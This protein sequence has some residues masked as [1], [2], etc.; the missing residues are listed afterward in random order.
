MVLRLP[1]GDGPIRARLAMQSAARVVGPD[2]RES[3]RIAIRKRPKHHGVDDAEHRGVGADAE[4]QRDDRDGREARRSAQATRG[5]AHILPDG[6]HGA[7]PATPAHLRL[8]RPD[9]SDLDTRRSL[10]SLARHSGAHFFVDGQLQVVPQL[11]VELL[12][13]RFPVEERSD[14]AAQRAPH[15]H[16]VMPPADARSPPRAAASPWFQP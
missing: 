1:V 2:E 12:L 16:D 6:F 5:I 10:G 14:S 11:V 9:A 7:L 4:R 15:A 13:D 8:R 3:A